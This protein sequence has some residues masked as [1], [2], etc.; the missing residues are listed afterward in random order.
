M[1][2]KRYWLRGG[3]AIAILSLI[4]GLFYIS[5]GSRSDIVTAIYSPAIIVAY[6]NGGLFS[7]NQPSIFQLLIFIILN[8]FIYGL[9][10]GWLY[11]K[12]KNKVT[13][14]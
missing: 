5:D 2:Q 12:I 1:K 13:T 11:G 9:V 6:M 14:K 4:I 8:G 3:I 10:L 7:S